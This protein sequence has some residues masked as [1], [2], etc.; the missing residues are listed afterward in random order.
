[1]RSPAA[2]GRALDR[3]RQ[4][5]P[6]RGVGVLGIEGPAGLGVD[7][8]GL[9]IGADAEL[10]GLRFFGLEK[11]VSD[12]DED[13]IS[14]AE[15]FDLPPAQQPRRRPDSEEAEAERARQPVGQ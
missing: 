3:E 6:D 2:A 1:E 8:R 10:L 7:Q 11:E 4:A 14:A 12:G 9:L 5:L 13:E 15:Q